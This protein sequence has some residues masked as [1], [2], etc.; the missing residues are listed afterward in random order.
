VNL[1]QFNLN[2]LV[3][4]PAQGGVRVSTTSVPPKITRREALATLAAASSLALF[5][6]CS[7]PA[8]G[9]AAAPVV[10]T[11]ASVPTPAGQP[12]D[13]A[14]AAGF[15]PVGPG[16]TSPDP[17]HPWTG[18]P[19]AGGSLRMGSLGD[20]PNLD[21]HFIN[22]SNTL[23]P[24]WDRLIDIDASL[25]PHPAL[26]QSWEVNSDYTQMTFHLKPGVQFHTGRVLTSA[27]V[28]WNYDRIKS[29]KKVDGGVKSN[30]FQ[31]LSSMETPD[32][33][34]IIL[35]SE[36]PWP[37]VFDLIAWVNIIDPETFQAKG[38]NAPVGT[39]PFTFVDW[40]QGDHYT[41]KKN[42]TY[43]RNGE[44]YVDQIVTQIFTDPQ[45]MITQ[46]EGG[47]LDV[48]IL[49]TIRDAVRLVKD[50]KY[51]VVYNQAS[52]S[53]NLI[54]LQCQPGASPT[55]NKLFRQALNYA[56][57]RQRWV[58]TVLLGVGTTK[59]LPVTPTNPAY[60]A[61][62]DSVYAFD[63]DKAK[64]LIQQSG[65]ANPS[66]EFLYNATSADYASV[67]QI[68]QADLASIGVTLT[69]K[70]QEQVTYID[71]LFNGKYPNLA[72]GMS[73]F[74]QLHPSFF[75]GNAYFSPVHNWENY[76]A[77]EYTQLGTGLLHEIDPAKQ[78]Q[79][80]AQ[81]LDYI[82]DQSFAV[83]W[84]NT[85]PRVV[86][87]AKVQGLKYNMTDFFMPNEA[88]LTA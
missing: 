83:T 16:P 87:T 43:W 52:G 38:G 44:P 86:A 23:Y 14:A 6:A 30:F 55:T 60:D 47:A 84:S 29:D 19:R 37:G 85:V 53:V 13:K 35:H 66:V 78:K 4:P 71:Q 82:L 33:S 59:D 57:N 17:L 65:V 63:L 15:L 3:A 12:Q 76:Q 24:V 61:A 56:I 77:D 58:D 69:L 26:A 25:N 28:M 54:A 72:G 40:V 42:P 10:P 50:P 7:G 41:L 64:A 48:A 18:Q 74:G 70:P 34:T 75:F 73:L 5:A 49:P 80:Y 20:L 39:G 62:K 27:D 81:W 21:G 22:G 68:Y 46:L 8:A 2:L 1:C 67:G 79:V 31:T 32:P 36:Q 51:Q 11:T 45:S 88:W 9:P